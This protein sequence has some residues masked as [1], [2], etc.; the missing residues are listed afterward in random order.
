LEV[1]LAV[2]P[3]TLGLYS[4]SYFYFILYQCGL[5]PLPFP[6]FQQIVEDENNGDDAPDLTFKRLQKRK[7]QFTFVSQMSKS[8]SALE[9]FFEYLSNSIYSSNVLLAMGIG[10]SVNN[11]KKVFFLQFHGLPDRSNDLLSNDQKLNDQMKNK[12]IEKLKRQFIQQLIQFQSDNDNSFSLASSTS[13]ISS[14]K[15]GNI[16]FFLQI[17]PFI[18]EEYSKLFP[19]KSIELMEMFSFLHKSPFP[20]DFLLSDSQKKPSFSA[21]RQRQIQKRIFHLKIHINENNQE[22][23]KEI[24]ICNDQQDQLSMGWLVSKNGIKVLKSF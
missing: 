20:S 1:P 16:F 2:M 14:I 9:D 6:Q 18:L 23:E 5:V 4:P 13:L 15:N 12:V 10:P 3:T 22:E 7:K 21:H 11:L 24:N 17:N 8:I 19:D